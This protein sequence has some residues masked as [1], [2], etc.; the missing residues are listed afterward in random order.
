M[1]I[2]KRYFC[3]IAA[4][5][6]GGGIWHASQHRPTGAAEGVEIQGVDLIAQYASANGSDKNTQ[7]FV[8]IEVKNDHRPSR[9][10]LGTFNIHS[11][12]GSD[13]HRDVDRVAKCMKGLDFVGLNEVQGAG[14]IEKQDQAAL[15]GRRL[16][17]AWLFAPSIRQWYCMESGNAMLTKVPVT[18]WHRIPLTRRVDYS[19]RNAVQV[20]LR[21]G[22]DVEGCVVHVLITHV[23][24]RY[25]SEREMQLD[26]VIPMFLAL[27]EPAVLLGDL[28]STA[29][30]AQI[31]QLMSSSGVIDAVG[32]V[33]GPKDPDRIDWIFVRGL[34]CLDAGIVENDA[35][36]HPLI[37]AE[38]ECS[39]D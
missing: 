37:W 36:D 6:V 33:L 29:K 16:G 15:L 23:N 21:L 28:N 38:L 32:Q 22:S 27:P 34:H 9:F 1:K 17:M 14:F 26:E 39:K 3:L 30:D 5:I 11:C 10:R 31:R 7:P 24:H 18:A 19:Y 8:D 2:R 4:L 35:S 20:D 12:K 25:D 13:G